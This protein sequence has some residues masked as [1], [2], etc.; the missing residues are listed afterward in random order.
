[1]IKNSDN[2]IYE[3]HIRMYDTNTERKGSLFNLVN[4]CIK[5]TK[6]LI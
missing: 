6:E 5:E 3:N 4:T 1:M 2:F